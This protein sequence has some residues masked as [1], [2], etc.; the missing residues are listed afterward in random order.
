MT[1]R[2]LSTGGTRLAWPSAVACVLLL[3]VFLLP[4]CRELVQSPT[5]PDASL[6]PIRILGL[7]GAPLTDGSFRI[8]DIRFR[9]S[10]RGL[11]ESHQISDDGLTYIDVPHGPYSIS[12]HPRPEICPEW[13]RL[14][15]E[16]GDQL[17]TLDPRNHVQPGQ[18]VVPEGLR[19]GT[20]D[21]QFD[22]FFEWNGRDDR[23]V[24][25]TRVDADGHFDFIWPMEGEFEVV[26]HRSGIRA[27]LKDRFF[28]PSPDSLAISWNPLD[29]E[30]EL[31][32][33]GQPVPEGVVEVQADT[34][35]PGYFALG[36]PPT[37]IVLEQPVV[38]SRV[39]VWAGPGAGA[40]VISSRE[41]P[42]FM[43][44]TVFVEFGVEELPV[45]ELGQ[46][47]VE[48]RFVTPEDSEIWGCDLEVTQAAS[49]SLLYASDLE[50]RETVYL[51][52]GDY[53]IRA[54]HRGASEDA[55]AVAT[56]TADTTITL[57][58]DP[59]SGAAP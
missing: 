20:Y 38:D 25:R 27:D 57:V 22:I 33:A 10:G 58:L 49:S 9:S 15:V 46:H 5:S 42:L 18:F 13:D 52:S 16:L 3:G 44:R 50:G 17:V 4:A 35:H 55:F 12:I 53:A 48:L 31:T 23:L 34:P 51:D 40:L 32:L 8:S 24:S 37:R 14:R 1:V 21:L 36:L 43:D 29:L 59:S 47:A 41:D 28:V 7:D 45:V 39:Q 54:R 26:V 30:V 6:T 11:T 19:S 56:V 2:G